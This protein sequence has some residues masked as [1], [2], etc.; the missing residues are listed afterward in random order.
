MDIAA[1]STTLLPGT[2]DATAPGG[3][4]G[5]DEFLELLITQMQNQDPLNPMSSEDTIAQLAQ[6]SSL[7]QMK[8]LNEQFDGFRKQG[9]LMDALL[10]EGQTVNLSLDGGESAYGMVEKVSWDDTKGGMILQ[11][12]GEEYPVKDII[13]ISRTEPVPVDEAVPVDETVPVL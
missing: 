12:G 1:T 13:G 4:L 11:M 8:N 7:E 3:A 2:Q 10:L 9:A 5:K 6:F